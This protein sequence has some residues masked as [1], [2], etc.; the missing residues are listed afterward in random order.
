MRQ[1]NSSE[2][3][4]TLIDEL[5]AE[6]RSMTA[7]HR[8]AQR[9]ADAKVPLQQK[10]YRDLLP[11]ARPQPGQQYSFE[12]DLD[13][14][15]GCKACVTAC[16]NLNGLEEN[17]TWRSVG[18]LVGGRGFNEQRTVTT[19]CHH[20]VDP[21]CLNGCPVLAYEKDPV[22]GIVS[23]LDD[24]CIGC[25]YCVLKCP[26]DVPQYSTRLGIV[27]KCDM[28][29]SRL[30]V[31]EA[32]ACVQAC[33]NEAIAIRVV[34]Q[35]DLMANYR[36]NATVSTEFLASAPEPGYTVPSTRY[37]SNHAESA[38]LEA[39]DLNDVSLQP[40]HW[41]LV[42]MLV[43]MQAASGT[44]LVHACVQSYLTTQ[45]S[46]ALLF[47]GAIWTILGLVTSVF[48]LGRPMGAWRIFLG[49]RRSWLS[50]E[51]LVLGA[52]AKLALSAP[53]LLW[54]FPQWGILHQGLAWVLGA[55]AIVGTITSV[56]VYHDTQRLAWKWRVSG[57]KFF[58][59]AVILGLATTISVLSFLKVGGAW[60]IQALCFALVLGSFG[61]L[62]GEFRLL[63]SW[64]VSDKMSLRK[65]S[66]LILETV[67]VISRGR[68]ALLVTGGLFLPVVV[69]L[70]PTSLGTALILLVTLVSAEVAER[71][72]FFTTVAPDKMPGGLR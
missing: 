32:P 24:Q 23:H 5:L 40:A 7:V 38:H 51:A 16:H 13:Q 61:K 37:V 46:M 64:I 19:A 62:L 8:F 17:E 50:R 70:K 9:H 18:L 2:S 29:S 12:V 69:F 47:V 68:N 20:C 22:T 14:C 33:P 65:T 72:L 42:L 43:L 56:M 58:G 57:G 11:L 30:A 53:L 71:F 35:G 52:M 49:W 54:Y 48:H 36:S 31:N 45:A 67:P 26:Y 27:R 6:Q 60:M 1:S 25:Q 21:A 15:S 3:N 66:M 10:Y 28:C 59:T 39:A 44:F 41:P 34:D 4:Q 63:R 55:V